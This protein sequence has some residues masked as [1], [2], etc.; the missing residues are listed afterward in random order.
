MFIAPLG[1]PSRTA[2]PTRRSEGLVPTTAEALLDQ[3]FHEEVTSLYDQHA[4]SFEELLSA[5]QYRTPQE[6]EKSLLAQ[7]ESI[8]PHGDGVLSRTVCLDLGCGTGLVG[9]LLRRRCTGQLSGCDLSGEMLKIAEAKAGIYDALTKS[10]CVSFLRQAAP[11]SAD[12]IIA[13]DVIVYMHGLT[14][15]FAAAAA[16]LSPGGKLAFSTEVCGLD[17]VSGGLPPSGPGWIERESERVAH[18]TEYIRWL[19]ERHAQELTLY[20]LRESTIRMDGG[21]DVKGSIVVLVKV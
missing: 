10:E 16:A 20:S 5:L 1:G 17:E 15:L 6:L 14:E 21:Q 3:R 8:S 18:A 4:H 11:A 13:C 9:S 7:L 12:L 19:V 2:E